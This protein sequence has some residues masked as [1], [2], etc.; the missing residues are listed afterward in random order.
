MK[1]LWKCVHW[2][3]PLTSNTDFKAAGYYCDYYD[4]TI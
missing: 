1:V 3:K 2:N 4:T